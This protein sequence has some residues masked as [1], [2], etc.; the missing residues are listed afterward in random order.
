MLGNSRESERLPN[1]EMGE[2]SETSIATKGKVMRA[3][4]RKNPFEVETG[5]GS[6]LCNHK[7]EAERRTDCN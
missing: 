2:A 7:S 6:A 5:R 3:K 4:R 1:E